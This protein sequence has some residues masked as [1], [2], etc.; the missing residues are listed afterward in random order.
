[1]TQRL[2]A[3]LRFRAVRVPGSAV[4]AL[5]VYLTSAQAAVAPSWRIE[6]IPR[7]YR[8]PSTLSAVS[9]GSS[10]SCVAVGDLEGPQVDQALI[11]RRTGGVWSRDPLSVGSGV[12]SAQL[13]G[14]SC[15]SPRACVAVGYASKGVLSQFTIAAHWDGSEWHLG[16]MPTTPGVMPV[17]SSVSCTSAS[18]CVAVGNQYAQQRGLPLVELWNGAAWLLQSVPGDTDLTGVS[19]TSRTACIAVGGVNGPPLIL[20]WNGRSWLVEKAPRLP[21]PRELSGVSCTSINRCVAAGGD[22]G[23]VARW[24]GRGWKVQR[25]RPSDTVVNGVSCASARSCWVVVTPGRSVPRAPEQLVRYWDGRSWSVQPTPLPADA[26]GGAEL[27]AISCG[28]RFGCTA[29]GDYAAPMRTL[30]VLIER[31]S[32][33]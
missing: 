19:C 32:G 22:T 11:L 8:V 1:V 3:S 10:K 27:L 14:V 30:P 17:L 12:V 20:R 24:D 6:S 21:F 25:L 23:A 5:L 28:L 15:T 18:F 31:R 7:P 9:C 33:A 2:S 16:A 29:V 13:F 26:I 4:V